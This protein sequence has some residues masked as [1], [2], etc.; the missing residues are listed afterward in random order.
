MAFP[1]QSG[2]VSSVAHM[3]LMDIE[4]M[5]PLVGRESSLVELCRKRDWPLTYLPSVSCIQRQETYYQV[6]LPF[7]SPRYLDRTLGPANDPNRV[8]RHTNQGM[9]QESRKHLP[10]PVAYQ[11]CSQALKKLLGHS[12]PSREQ[13]LR[14]KRFDRMGPRMRFEKELANRT[15]S[16]PEGI[17]GIATF[18]APERKGR[19]CSIYSAALKVSFRDASGKVR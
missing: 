3:A 14:P 18:V 7:P 19:H 2:T 11:R 4:S 5:G 16:R 12:H 8:V 17:V 10:P 13:Y 15:E 6:E 9:T 1:G